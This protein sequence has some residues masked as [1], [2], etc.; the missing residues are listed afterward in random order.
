MAAEKGNG[1]V[2]RRPTI[3]KNM[4]NPNPL[5]GSISIPQPFDLDVCL[6]SGQ[7]FGWF[8]HEN[9]WIGSIRQTAFA[10]RQEKDRL[11]Y[12]ASAPASAPLDMILRDYFAIDEDCEKIRRLLPRDPFLR[13]AIRFGSG[14][15][16]LHQDPWECL[17]EFILSSTKK[18]VHIRQ[19]WRRMSERWG[20]PL[21][22]RNSSP[23]RRDRE[24][25]TAKAG[26]GSQKLKLKTEAASPISTQYSHLAKAYPTTPKRFVATASGVARAVLSTHVVHSFPAPDQIAPLSE[27]DLRAC[28]MGFRAPY[29][30]QASRAVASGE[31][32]L[33]SLRHLS[34]EEARIRLMQL[35]GVGEKIADCVL[36]FSLGKT[37]AFPVDTW[38][39]KVLRQVYFHNKRR[40]KPSQLRSFAATHFGPYGG[41]AQQYLFHYARMNPHLFQTDFGRLG[42]RPSLVGDPSPAVA[43]SG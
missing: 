3:V 9:C 38:I 22:I 23:P 25:I 13:A 29:L 33:E 24:F 32:N 18:I 6:N 12:Q 43:G 10:L 1:G 26:Q 21:R 20:T 42:W 37:G 35:H 27:T 14:L 36:L 2:E 17:A 41:L 19:I 34:A 28:G 15:R 8:R 16:I 39:L 11:L 5:E 4:R 30:L 7:A 31:L 40:V